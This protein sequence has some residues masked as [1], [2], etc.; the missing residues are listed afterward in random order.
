MLGLILVE[1]ADH[2]NHDASLQLLLID[3]FLNLRFILHDWEFRFVYHFF[4]FVGL[5]ALIFAVNIGGYTTCCIL[6]VLVCF[7]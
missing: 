6:A 7:S 3:V 2:K 4:V 1:V 5:K